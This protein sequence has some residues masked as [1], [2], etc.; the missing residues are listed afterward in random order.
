[1]ADTS[2]NSKIKVSGHLEERYGSYRMVLS[3]ID[4]AGNRQRKSIATGLPIKGNKKRAEDMLYDT[5]K[6]HE[7]SLSGIPRLDKL[8]FA[9][10]LEHWLTVIRDDVKK[11]IKPTTFGGYQMNVQKVIAPYFRKKEILLIELTADDINDFYDEQLE[12]VTAMTVTKFHANISKALKYAVKENY[13]PHTNMDKVNRPSAKRFVGKVMKQSEMVS[14]FEASIGHRLELGIILGAF[15]GLRRSEVVGLRWESI[16]FEANTITIEHTVTEA[17]IDGKLVLIADDT[18]K[19]KSSFR[20][21][22]LV[23]SIRNKLL[24]V[25]AEQELNRKMCGKAYNKIEGRYIYTDS[26]GNRIKP[27]YLTAAFPTFLKNNGF[28]RMRYHDLRHSC[29]SLLPCQWCVAQADTRVAWA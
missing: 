6:N 8:L 9:D 10:F 22:P 26:L 27:N 3:W 13:I 1:M 19:S 2:T 7:A 24:N 18:T 28:Q 14:L 17:N 21:L 15:Y 5:K 20:T 11:P 12:R 25:K 4:T 29:A 23:P 16:D